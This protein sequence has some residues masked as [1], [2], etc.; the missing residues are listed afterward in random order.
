MGWFKK[1]YSDHGSA[2]GRQN[3]FDLPSDAHIDS[4]RQKAKEI[5]KE[6]PPPVEK[7]L[8]ARLPSPL[9]PGKPLLGL[10]IDV[11]THEGMRDGVP[12]LLDLLKE[13]GVH[14]TFYFAMGPDNSGRAILNVLARPGFLRKM[15]RSGAPK[16]YSLRTMLSG[17]LLPARKVALAFPGVARRTVEEG[18]EAGVHGWDHR[19]WQDRLPKYPSGRVILELERAADA[20]VEIF[21]AKPLTFASPAWLCSKESLFHQER[22]GLLYGSDCRGTDPFLPVIDYRVLQTP[23]V[24]ATLPTLDETLGDVDRDAPSFFARM[25]EESLGQEWPV[26]TIHAELEGGPFAPDFAAFLKSAQ[27]RGVA[28]VPLAVLLAT[29]LATGLPLPHCTLSYGVVEGRHGVVSCQML[30]V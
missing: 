15:L 14:G 7:A 23:Q 11:D 5:P 1:P 12:R 26:L 29:R 19:A 6:V 22:M 16:I 30:E 18:H 10:R 25:L 20:F 13:A 21:S 9:P 2:M 3:I 4:V 8:A 28:V 17:T 24:P 27:E